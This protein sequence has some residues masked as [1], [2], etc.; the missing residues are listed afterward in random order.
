MTA[1]QFNL[2]DEAWIPVANAG[3]VSLRNIFTCPDLQ[4][5]GGT[6][7]QKIALLKL[8]GAIAQAA[9]TPENDHEW[10]SMGPADLS[11]AVLVYLDQWHEAFWLYGDAPFLQMPGVK[12]A[13]LLGY[14]AIIPEVSSG[15]TS[16]LTQW[17]VC[18]TLSDA[19]KALLLLVNMSCCF[20]GKKADK[21]IVL[22]AGHS[23]GSAKSGPALCSIGLLH[24]FLMG[25]TIQETVWLNLL[26]QQCIRSYAVF[27]EGLGTPPWENM[28]LGEICPTAE[29]LKNSIMGRLVPLARFCLLE[30]DGL[31]YVEGIQHPDYQQ[32]YADPS[33]S[34]RAAS[35]KTQM[36]WCDPAK[37]PWRSLAALLSFV[38]D[39]NSSSWRCPL[40]Y[41]G[42]SRLHEGKVASFGLWSGGIKVSSNAGEQYL[43]GADDIMESEIMLDTQT[44]FSEIWFSQLQAQMTKLETMAKV[45]EMSVIAYYN[46]FKDGSA[47]DYAHRA[48]HHFW[49]LAEA[50]FPDLLNACTENAEARRTVMQR[51]VNAATT[52][53]ELT[54][55]QDTARQLQSWA[56]CR[57]KLGKFLTDQ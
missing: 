25:G 44:L 16:V 23:K 5:L 36:L 54:C 14:D 34:S 45:L 55:P 51:M 47:S 32:G 7:L 49:Q 50:N 3:L 10:A 9:F 27:S 24:T 6:A 26:T 40:V 28:P 1:K 33:A 42:V 46:N 31:R 8:L 11:K 21:S 30:N 57:P 15:N 38:L 53:F 48:A 20:G 39:Q 56:Q 35:K 37:R 17:H 22:S 52:A 41:H 19:D 29:K 2:V 43:S 13:A 12:K 18:P 4:S